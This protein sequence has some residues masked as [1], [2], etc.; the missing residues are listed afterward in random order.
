M[1]RSCVVPSTGSWS[2]HPRM[3]IK[4]LF[5]NLHELGAQLGYLTRYQR[6]HTCRKRTCCCLL[7]CVAAVA[8]TWATL[9]KGGFAAVSMAVEKNLSA[10]YSGPLFNKRHRRGETRKK[11][12]CFPL[13]RRITKLKCVNSEVN[14]VSILPNGFPQVGPW[15]HVGATMENNTRQEID[16]SS[17]QL[18]TESHTCETKQDQEK[19]ESSTKYS[20]EIRCRNMWKVEK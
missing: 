6:D 9:E 12:E 17:D 20:S 16:P 1:Q 14:S 13:R 19:R 8:S 3:G 10:Q 4:R 5:T 2:V 7:T 18:G 15:H 11:D